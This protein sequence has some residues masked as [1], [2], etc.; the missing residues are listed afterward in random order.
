VKALTEPELGAMLTV[1]LSAVAL[2]GVKVIV[3]VLQVEPAVTV[4]LAQVPP[5]IAKSA[6]LLVKGVA[7]KI[8]V[9]PTAVKVT[10]PQGVARPSAAFPQEGTVPTET[11]PAP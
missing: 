4:A 9:P 5:V 11:D 7:P 1:V 3:P 2:E 6:L 8:T 10:G